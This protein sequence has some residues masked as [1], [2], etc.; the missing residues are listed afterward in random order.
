[1]K[2]PAS[3]YF[4]YSLGM[5]PALILF[6]YIYLTMFLPNVGP[7]PDIHIEITDERVE[8][9]KYLANHVML[10]MDCHA[11]RDFSL[12]AGPPEP[13]S[14][15]G[16]GE[17]FDQEMGLPGYF[18]SKNITPAAL[19][20]WTDG[21]IY[22]AITSGVSKDGSALFPLMPYY[23][24]AELADEDIYAV[25]AYLRTL[26]P[27]QNEIPPAQLDFPVSILINTMP[28]K[29]NP[30]PKPSPDDVV[31]YGRYMIT[32]SACTDCH[33]RME[34]GSFVGEPF[35]GG[36]AYP[37]PDGSIVRSANITPHETGIGSWSKEEFINRF[38]VYA[39][40]SYTPHTVQSGQ[41]QT[42]MPWLMYAGMTEEDLGA[43]YEYLRTV[44][45][46]ENEIEIFTSAQ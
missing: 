3:R 35:A 27:I 1:M 11:V 12:Y 26:E 10:C 20:D 37:L 44:E 46:V 32:A 30:Q 13:G 9:G 29:A 17:V 6:G 15:G 19:G 23:H 2:K 40:P 8:H 22:R 25:I 42:Y 4:V 31:N 36:N 33:T 34:R 28:I 5:I 45:P 7:A 38:K 24:Y 21:E 39:D 14:L 41:F 16:G 18:V 43:I